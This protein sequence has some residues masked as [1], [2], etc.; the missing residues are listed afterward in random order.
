MIKST[1]QIIIILILFNGSNQSE[2]ATHLLLNYVA[3][4]VA[5]LLFI[6]RAQRPCLHLRKHIVQ[7]HHS[8][9]T[10]VAGNYQGKT[11]G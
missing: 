7:G 2:V 1:L 9:S 10:K 5:R 6:V 8:S 3:K 11:T 4:W